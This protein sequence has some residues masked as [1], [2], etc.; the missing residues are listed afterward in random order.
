MSEQN[1]NDQ[2]NQDVATKHLRV[3]VQ[4]L[5]VATRRG[6]FELEEAGTIS[7]AIKFFNMEN[8]ERDE[9]KQLEYIRTL[10]GMCEVAQKRGVFNLAESYTIYPNVKFFLQE[11]PVV[12]EEQNKPEDNSESKDFCGKDTCDPEKC[13]CPPDN[14]P[15]DEEN[16]CGTSAD[17][18]CCDA[19]KC[20]CP[21]DGTECS[22]E[23]C[24]ENNCKPNI[25]QTIEKAKPSVNKEAGWNAGDY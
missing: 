14:C 21:S 11:P 17:A 19:G 2:S 3:M 20:P 1:Q 5:Q 13:P 25:E 4:A 15:C 24:K 7:E 23:K 22:P 8:K 16:N 12:E 9:E 18:G 10:V 6:A